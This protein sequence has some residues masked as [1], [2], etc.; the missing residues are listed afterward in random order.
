[1]EKEIPLKNHTHNGVDS[2]QITG[3]S[4]SGCPMTALTAQS[5]NLSTGGAAVLTTSD[6]DTIMNTINRVIELENKLRS[7][8][9]II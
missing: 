2:L 6:S 8:G 5:G 4:I 3:A 1:M 9:I 7:I